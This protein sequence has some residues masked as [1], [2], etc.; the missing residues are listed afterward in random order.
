M[1]LDVSGLVNIT[2]TCATNVRKVVQKKQR[3]IRKKECDNTCTGY[4]SD[5]WSLFFSWYSNVMSVSLFTFPTNTYPKALVTCFKNGIKG[6][7]YLSLVWSTIAGSTCRCEIQ[8][9]VNECE[10]IGFHGLNRVIE[11]HPHLSLEFCKIR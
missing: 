8:L 4:L 7:R 11:N 10:H 2:C 3:R 6:E 5:V 1:S 9:W